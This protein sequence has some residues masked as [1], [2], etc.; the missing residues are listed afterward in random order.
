[1][2][3]FYGK[4][5]IMVN[6]TV[7]QMRDI[8]NHTKNIR[9]MS[10]VTHV[11]HGKCFR[12]GSVI[13][14]ADGSVRRVEHL[15]VGDQLLGDDGTPRTVLQTHTG[16]GEIF[17]IHQSG[18]EPYYVNG[19]HILCL[20]AVGTDIVSF[21]PKK[22]GYVTRCLCDTSKGLRLCK[23]VFTKHSNM[24]LDLTDLCKSATEFLTD[25]SYLF[26]GYFAPGDIVEISVRDFMQLPVRVRQCLR[27]YRVGY[28]FNQDHA[29]RD[30]DGHHLPAFY[31]WGKLEDQIE[32][33]DVLLQNCAVRD[34]QRDEY[35]ILNEH[36]HFIRDLQ[37]MVRSL[38]YGAYVLASGTGLRINLT[39]SGLSRISVKSVG[40]DQYY[41]FQL[42]GNQRHLLMDFTVTHNST[43]SNSLLAKTG[44]IKAESSSEVSGMDA[45]QDEKD[46]GNTIKSTG[47][48]LY[49]ELTDH[50]LPKDG[51]SNQFLINLVDSPGHVDFSS[52]VTTTPLLPMEL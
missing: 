29:P 4:Q 33:L 2:A 51:E 52:E 30:N 39:S 24:E 16:R 32:I 19:N 21:V 34:E 31:K 42:D 36:P 8:M 10:L 11:D 15:C 41:G 35:L 14:L 47:V 13:P 1:M 48:S 12:K 18:G 22:M 17:E 45:R 26:I 27:G 40:E 44:I 6:F 25:Q 20:K 49:Y 5:A 7:E 38:G 43:L 3:L 46:S 28:S 37:F 9:D 50:L 23:T